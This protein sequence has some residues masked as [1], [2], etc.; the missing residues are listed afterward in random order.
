MLYCSIIML[1]MRE[2]QALKDIKHKE[3]LELYRRTLT[4]VSR[5]KLSNLDVTL[6][7]S[8]MG[9]GFSFGVTVIDRKTYNN[10]TVT[11]YDFYSAEKNEL[12][13]EN[14]ITVVN[15]EK[16]RNHHP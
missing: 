14:I 9:R 10:R 16:H 1:S 8:F 7:A 5:S 6:S 12:V 15:P 3:M 2:K 4:K 11:A 13:I